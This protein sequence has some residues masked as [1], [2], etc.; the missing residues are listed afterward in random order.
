MLCA[1]LPHGPTADSPEP[2]D[3]VEDRQ[4]L[5]RLAVWCE[6][7]SP[8][9]AVDEF[10]TCDTLLLDVT[11]VAHLFGGEAHLAR[12]VVGRF[13]GRGLPVRVAVANTVGAAWGVAH[14]GRDMADGDFRSVP[15]F[16]HPQAAIGNPELSS[17]PLPALRLVPETVRLLDA[18][19]VHTIAHLAA[20]PRDQLAP[21]F[22]PQLLRR[23]DQFTG[24]C[25][26][27]LVAYR[28]PPVA[29]AQ[30]LWEYPVWRRDAVQAVVGGL[31]ERI[32]DQLFQRG[33]GVLRLNCRLA[34]QNGAALQIPVGLYQPSANPA[35]LLGLVELQLERLRIGQPVTAVEVTTTASDR[36]AV[37]QLELAGGGIPHGAGVAGGADQRRQLAQLVDRLSSRLG[38]A[39]VLA[40][41]LLADAIPECACRLEPLAG[42]PNG[43]AAPHPSSA[44]KSRRVGGAGSAG[45]GRSVAPIRFRPLWLNPHPIAIPVMALHPDGPPLRFRWSGRAYE[46]AAWWGP[47]RIETGWWRRRAGRR[48][49]R[50]YY[51]V[52]TAD[53]QRF[54]LFRHR[55]D[56]RWFL[57]G[58]FD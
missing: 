40:P 45:R 29:T 27:T 11:G 15:P 53:G 58:E 33:E 49:R 10:E 30:H 54:W 6:Q 48:V 47:E 26:E 18:L 39:A 35:H 28:Q 4:A 2:R 9:V 34:L 36:L 21:R 17:L 7:F 51:R 13:Q 20:L 5:E 24:V 42:R 46:V 38:R 57:H 19:G 44:G 12:Q 41:R 56:Q 31:I 16:W 37:R 55:D 50:D 43:G 3:A 14:F 8:L 32:C 1:W 25:P 52:E 22:G 23:L